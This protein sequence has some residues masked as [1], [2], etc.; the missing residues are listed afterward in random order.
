MG[1]AQDQIFVLVTMDTVLQTVPLSHVLEFLI[2]TPKYVHLMV[3]VLDQTLAIVQQVIQ[4]PIVNL[5]FV[6]ESLLHLLLF[7]RVEVH[8]Q[9]QIIAIVDQVILELNVKQSPIR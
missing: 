4:E 9:L 2:Q 1:N 7:A 5:L 6:M 3:L 8:V